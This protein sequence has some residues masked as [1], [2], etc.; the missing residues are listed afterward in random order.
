MAVSFESLPIIDFQA[1]Q[2][3]ATKSEALADLKN[4]LF[5]VGFLYLAN[6]GL[7]S[8]IEETHNA[9]PQIF[10]LPESDKQRCSMLN[11]P[12]FLGYTGLGAET[13]ARKT[14]LREQFDFGSPVKSVWKE[15][16]LPW[17]RLEGPSQFPNEEVNKLVTRYTSELSVL[18]GTF[19]RAVAECLSLP[20]GTFETFLGKMHRLKFV[21]YPRSEPGSQGVGPH[22]DSTGLFTFLSQDSVGGLEVLNRAGQWISAPYIKGTLVVNVQ[23]GFEAIT[24]GLCPA[25]THR[26]L[27]PTTTTRYSIP[28]FQAVRLDLTLKFLEE[29]AVDIVHRIPT[30]NVANAQQVTIPS[31]FMSPL[32]SCF[33]EAQLRNRIMS[34]PDVG[35]RWYL[36]LYEKYSRQ[37]LA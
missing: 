26:V 2:S 14:D 11:S 37:T 35:K 36:E 21:K 33:G 5:H 31:E 18:S 25:T 7:E 30:Q 3:D 10:D 20:S 24:G 34:H 12:S 17:Q 27:A 4:A 23:Q 28:F 19:L 22:K 13:T 16:D 1:L 15:G 29:A 32:F 8:I 6:T 9:L